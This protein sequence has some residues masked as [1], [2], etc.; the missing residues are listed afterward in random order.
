MFAAG[1]I[2]EV[3]ALQGYQKPL[4]HEARQALGYKEVLDFL[5]AQANL[6]ET[7]ER[8]KTR[9][10]NFAKRQITWFRHLPGCQSATPQLTQALWQPKMERLETFDGHEKRSSE[11]FRR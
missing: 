8:I 4:S 5:D 3:K 10:R 9:T 1:L 2:E 7:K 11:L 6:E